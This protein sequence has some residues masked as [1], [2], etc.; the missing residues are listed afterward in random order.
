MQGIHLR[1]L[2]STRLKKPA[3]LIFSIFAMQRH[4]PCTG[5]GLP[6]KIY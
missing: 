5:H 1:E 6:E 2:P 4:F 3:K